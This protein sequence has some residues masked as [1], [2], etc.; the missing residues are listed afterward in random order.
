M[1]REDKMELLNPQRKKRRSNKKAEAGNAR[2]CEKYIKGT[3][4]EKAMPLHIR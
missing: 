2:L 1:P 3:T 4:M